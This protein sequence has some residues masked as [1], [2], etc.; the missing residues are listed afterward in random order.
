MHPLLTLLAMF[1]G[2]KLYG[3][4]GMIFFI[5]IGMVIVNMY[6]IGMFNQL[7]RGIKIIV[8]DLNEF[9]KY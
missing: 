8:H 3:V 2:Y 1:I 4:I 7:I 6:R 5:P 9:R